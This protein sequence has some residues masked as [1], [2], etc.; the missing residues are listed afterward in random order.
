[1]TILKILLI[2]AINSVLSKLILSPLEKKFRVLLFVISL[3]VFISIVTLIKNNA[4]LVFS[5]PLSLVWSLTIILLHYIFSFS[6]LEVLKKKESKL[7][8]PLFKS[9]REIVIKYCYPLL[10]TIGQCVMELNPTI[11]LE[12]I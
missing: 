7:I 10:V 11:F 3:I 12:S 6:E 9:F 5:F 4:Y 8:F 1:M 2:V